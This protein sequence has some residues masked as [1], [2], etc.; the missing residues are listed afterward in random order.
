M[1][2]RNFFGA[3]FG[4][5][6]FLH[7]TRAEVG[8]AGVE[9][10]DKMPAKPS[11][12]HAILENYF[13]K[14]GG[15]F[16][17]ITRRKDML[18][19]K[20][21]QK[22]VKALQQAMKD[23]G[24][25]EQAKTELAK[26]DSEFR[27]KIEEQMMGDSWVKL[28]SASL[29][30]FDK[31]GA[32]MWS[33]ASDGDYGHAT[34]LAVAYVQWLA[35]V[36]VDGAFGKGSMKQLEQAE[37][38]ARIKALEEEAKEDTAA[39]LKDFQ[40]SWMEEFV[41]DDSGS[42]DV[43]ADEEPDA[44]TDDGVDA[45]SPS[46]TLN[47]AEVVARKAGVAA[48]LTAIAGRAVGLGDVF[49]L[50]EGYHEQT[51]FSQKGA[52][53]GVSE[54]EW[55]NST[56]NGWFTLVGSDSTPASEGGAAKFELSVSVA[57]PSKVMLKVTWG[58]G[59]G[60]AGETTVVTDT[61]LVNPTKTEVEDK[62]S[63]LKRKADMGIGG[64]E[65]EEESAS[66][67]AEPARPRPDEEPEEASDA[68]VE[69]RQ[70]GVGA[71][72]SQLNG[73]VLG[74]P[75]NLGGGQFVPD[76]GN[77]GLANSDAWKAEGAYY[78]M[79][80]TYESSGNHSVQLKIAVN[81]PHKIKIVFDGSVQSEEYTAG[82]KRELERAI[83]ERKSAVGRAA[84]A[85]PGNKAVVAGVLTELGCPGIGSPLD[86]GGYNFRPLAMSDTEW[87]SRSPMN[88][89]YMLAVDMPN[90]GRVA[91][92]INK[93]NG[94]VEIQ[95]VGERL[96]NSERMS[97]AGGRR[98]QVEQF[99]TRAKQAFDKKKAV[100]DSIKN[101]NPGDDLSL[102]LG[103]EKVV[104]VSTLAGNEGADWWLDATD[105]PMQFAG[106]VPVKGQFLLVIAN[107][108]KDNPLNVT[109]TLAAPEDLRAID[110]NEIKAEGVTKDQLEAKFAEIK[111]K[112]EKAVRKKTVVDAL[113]R[114]AGAAVNIDA[115]FVVGGVTFTFEGGAERWNTDGLVKAN[116]EVKGVPIKL[117]VRNDDAKMQLKSAESNSGDALAEARNQTPAT[118]GNVLKGLVRAEL[119]DVVV[120]AGK[121]LDVRA[122]VLN[123]SINYHGVRFD[124]V[125]FGSLSD[126]NVWMKP[127]TFLERKSP[128]IVA[129]G[130][131]L[132]LSISLTKPAK[133]YLRETS[134]LTGISERYEVPQ[135][136]L[137]TAIDG[138]KERV[139]IAFY[140]NQAVAKLSA[141]GVRSVAYG[142][143]FVSDDWN[144][145]CVGLDDAE[146]KSKT[147]TLWFKSRET[148]KGRN[149]Y[150]GMD[151]AAGQMVASFGASDA[152]RESNKMTFDG[153]KDA[154]ENY[155]ENTKERFDGDQFGVHA[156][157]E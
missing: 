109:F 62:M 90:I 15:K 7:E 11:A 48:R 122:T 51:Q 84:E 147:G 97:T 25:Y 132:T 73:G 63:D 56:M 50:N 12:T 106:E 44:G 70:R 83:G 133:Y 151:I 64:G 88:T 123:T 150:L 129:K 124:P 149:I 23:A 148:E 136:N 61:P 40:E 66:G 74:Q 65:P 69:E 24:I 60:G 107:T 108:S 140:K 17:S 120:D 145:Q 36:K 80:H 9:N 126:D 113:G 76:G 13:N 152:E 130:S 93:N 5:A 28:F 14:L 19:D 52:D 153:S 157:F 100:F 26:S 134:T 1:N 99:L 143:T 98:S 37:V 155:V 38:E 43:G 3:G 117:L 6:R 96:F 91:I 34:R 47:A 8:G 87:V 53:G 105:K 131:Y 22:G 18:K 119:E 154:F 29:N 138:F 82:Q 21:A 111:A 102:T 125:N 79:T 75:L 118:F 57:D 78:V 68:T 104:L 32:A 114:V 95:C 72:L 101:L 139:Q 55:A 141:Y 30:K 121:A 54:G 144:F 94:N 10:T 127:D 31:Q 45:D 116:G 135:A 2:Y 71:V 42:A 85:L 33:D 156:M 110:G 115:P 39:K 92:A 27:K 49:T 46:E 142:A 16:F 35:G 128:D 103:S 58:A 77:G 67:G 59:R 20:D 86:L 81:S 112:V 137:G 41:E 89:N 4:E 146:W